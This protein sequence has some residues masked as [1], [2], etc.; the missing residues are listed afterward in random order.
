[1]FL[2]VSEGVYYIY[3][4]YCYGPV[5]FSKPVIHREPIVLGSNGISVYVSATN[6]LL[7][8][9]MQEKYFGSQM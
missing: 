6:C 1:M 2:V 8:I 7:T 9:G 3:A 4:N 5:K